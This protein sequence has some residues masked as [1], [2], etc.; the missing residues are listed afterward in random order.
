[1]GKAILA[2][3]AVLML[4]GSSEARGRKAKPVVCESYSIVEDRGGSEEL[5][6]VCYDK[7]VE[8]GLT[9]RYWREVNIP[10][11][12]TWDKVVTVVIGWR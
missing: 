3:L 5:V 8:G 10:A 2:G 9:L 12:G 11:Q 4:A 1:M 6:A 7:H